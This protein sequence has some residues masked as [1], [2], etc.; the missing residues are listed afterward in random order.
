MESFKKGGFGGAKMF[1]KDDL[2]NLSAE[3]IAQKVIQQPR[4][5]GVGSGSVGGG[6]CGGRSL[7]VVCGERERDAAV[8]VDTGQEAE[9]E[10]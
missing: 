10:E 5:V 8:P 4:T 9:R 2:E 6:R 1:S 7:G 3:D